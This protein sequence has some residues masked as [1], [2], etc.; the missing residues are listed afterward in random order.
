MKK[1]Q[2]KLNDTFFSN[3]IEKDNVYT[4]MKEWEYTGHYEDC[5]DPTHTCE[6]CGYPRIRYKFQIHNRNTNVSLLIGSHCI[7]DFGTGCAIQDLSKLMQDKTDLLNKI[8]RDKT[9]KNKADREKEKIERERVESL[10]KRSQEADRRRGTIQGI[11]DQATD[12]EK[13]GIKAIVTIFNKDTWMAS[14]MDMEEIVQRFSEGRLTAGQIVFLYKKSLR[15]KVI[16]DV[17]S[18][19]PRLKY[20]DDYRK[21]FDMSDSDKSIIKRFMDR[22]LRREMEQAD[23]SYNWF[24][25]YQSSQSHSYG[26]SSLSDDMDQDYIDYHN[27]HRDRD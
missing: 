3:S 25:S 2:S 21:I 11:Y 12:T 24:T 6:L 10:R 1:H 17:C 5:G 15:Y 14:H 20:N 27:R 13:C 9:A 19:T 16:L 23:P 7:E 26:P 22:N 8:A 18:F 4:A